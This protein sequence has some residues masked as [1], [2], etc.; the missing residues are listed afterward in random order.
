MDHTRGSVD[1]IPTVEE[2]IS[3]FEEFK[4]IPQ[5]SLR[6]CQL[7]S[8]ENSTIREI[9]EVLRLDPI[10]VSRLLRMVNSAYYSIRN[11]IESI[12]KAVVFIGLKNLRNLMVIDTM[13]DC[14][15]RESRDHCFRR[16]ASGCIAQLSACVRK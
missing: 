14:F 1:I 7:I 12:S 3:H 6:V 4:T 16:S 15:L 13:K 11:R 5:I 2:F 9:E 8:K 10:L